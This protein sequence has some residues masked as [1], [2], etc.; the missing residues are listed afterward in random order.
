MGENNA[1]QFTAIGALSDAVL[2]YFD[3]DKKACLTRGNVG[4]S[5]TRGNRIVETALASWGGRSAW[6][7]Q[8]PTVLL[9]KSKRIPKNAR[10]EFGRDPPRRHAS[11]Q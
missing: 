4:G 8:N 2:M 7:N 3:W 9:L 6:R 10:R 1:A 5:H 11:A